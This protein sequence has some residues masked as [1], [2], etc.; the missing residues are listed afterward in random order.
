[1]H[2]GNTT[3]TTPKKESES[4][5]LH[6]CGHATLHSLHLKKGRIRPLMSG[7]ARRPRATATA[8][9]PPHPMRM[10]VCHL[11]GPPASSKRRPAVACAG[12]AARASGRPTSRSDTVHAD[13]ACCV[14]RGPARRMRSGESS[15][16]TW[17][18]RGKE[19]AQGCAN[20]ARC[21]SIGLGGLF[22]QFL[23]MRKLIR[24]RQV[25]GLITPTLRRAWSE[26]TQ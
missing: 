7:T 4:P 25:A 12:R 24:S 19:L 16:R 6:A 23:H 26:G 9:A 3:D 20:F 8:R 13:R 17:R 11:A 22:D 1:M 5:G 10:K 14:D 21:G 18:L 2:S 15:V